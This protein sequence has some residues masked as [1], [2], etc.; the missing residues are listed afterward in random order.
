LTRGHS[1]QI[2][3]PRDIC[4]ATTIDPTEIAP[5]EEAVTPDLRRLREFLEHGTPGPHYYVVLLGLQVFDVARILKTVRQGLSYTALERFQRNTAWPAD[6]VIDWL[7]ISPR[8][9]TRRKQQGRLTPEESDRL[10][11][12][13]RIFA[14]AVELFEGNRDSAADW[15]SSPQHALG[16]AIPIDF[17]KTDIGSR[18]V[19]NL[20]ERL[21][22]GVFS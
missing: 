19:E 17:A 8:T 21:E 3:T 7:Q 18:E 10:L 22:H 16:G 9:L 1:A 20:I 6:E 2:M 12:A 4:M 13:S 14:K 11:R 15:L 5:R